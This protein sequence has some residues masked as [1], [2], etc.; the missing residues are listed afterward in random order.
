MNINEVAKMLEKNQESQGKLSVLFV[1]KKGTKYQAYQPQVSNKVQQDVIKLFKEH[2]ETIIAKDLKERE[3]NPSGQ[4]NDEYSVC[5]YEYV[6]NFHEVTSLYKNTKEEEMRAD[7][8][9]FLIFRL[10]I[11]E[12]ENPIK[13]LYL[14]RKNHKLKNIRKGFWI[15]KISDTYD[16][17]SDSDLIGI[18]GS[19]DAIAFEDE[20]AFFSHISAERIFNLREKFAQ[21]ARKVLN[22]I[23]DGGRIDNFDEF[24]EECLNDV[25]ITRRLTKMHS[26]PR[27]VKLFHEYFSNAQEVVELFDLNIS[28]NE[29]NTKIVYSHKD[30]LKDITMLMRDAYYRT[31]LADRKG[32]DDFN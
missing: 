6:G 31:I 16:K 25:R 32:I 23:E 24:K 15:R 10:R 26:N 2:L 29:D 8:I 22:E 27:I 9:N 12:D 11:N 17:L 4:P 3:F 30:E 21:N 28:F 20:L 19:I 5:S 7:Q 18:D 14:F 13:Y 1:S